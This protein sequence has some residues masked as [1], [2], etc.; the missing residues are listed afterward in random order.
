MRMRIG[1]LVP[2]THGDWL[3]VG[4]SKVKVIDASLGDNVKTIKWNLSLVYN[5]LRIGI[6]LLHS[7]TKFVCF[8]LRRWLLSWGE[9]IQGPFPCS[10]PPV[11][12]AFHKN[13]IV[14]WQEQSKEKGTLTL[15]SSRS[16]ISLTSTAFRSNEIM[17]LRSEIRS[18][19]CQIPRLSTTSE[20]VLEKVRAQ[21]GT[22]F[23]NSGRPAQ[24]YNLCLRL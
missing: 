10:L 13:Q 4:E 5:Q 12:H 21:S 24:I 9:F 19:F 14:N 15:P 2:P 16:S 18:P 17:R 8:C 23:F 11:N 22:S 3:G 7:F 1:H 20:Q 6:L